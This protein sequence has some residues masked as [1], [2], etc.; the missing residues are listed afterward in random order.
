MS[1]VAS[2]RRG[3]R[4]RTGRLVAV[5]AVWLLSG[6]LVTGWH[7][8]AQAAPRL[9][10]STPERDESIPAG[11]PVEVVLRFDET[12]RTEGASLVLLDE[13]GHRRMTAT[14]HVDGA[15]LDGLMPEVPP[16]D[17]RASYRA[18]TTSGDEVSGTLPF[19]ISAP[20]L[21]L[22]GMEV[23]RWAPTALIV[24]FVG[25][26]GVTVIAIMATASRR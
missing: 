22:L 18:T 21:S 1:A 9:E 3:D 7:G 5:I 12:L 14:V 8:T 16:G 20:A 10:S 11:G 17:Y 25:L 24:L 19:S 15:T 4:G 6:L 26:A 23:P 2:P 13:D